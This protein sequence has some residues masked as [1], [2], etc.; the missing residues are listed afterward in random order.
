M[1]VKGS[2]KYPA[3]WSCST[4]GDAFAFL[5]TANNAREDLT[6]TDG[7][8]YLHY[9]DIHTKWRTVLDLNVADLP[10]IDENKVAGFSP[11]QDG[12]L[13]IA[14]ASEDYDG[15]GVAV[16]VRNIKEKKAVAGLHTLLLREKGSIF[17]NGFKGYLQYV[18][19]VRSQ[20][21]KIATGVSVYSISK[22]NLAN[23]S[24]PVPSSEE[25]RS[26]SAALSDVDALIKALDR[27]IA[28][29]RDIKQA[30]MQELLTG[31]RRLP[32]FEGEWVT[33][34]IKDLLSYEQPNQYIVQDTEYS[35]HGDIPVITANKSFVL[36]YTMEKFG[37]CGNIPAI[38]FDDFTIDCKYVNFPFK[39]KSS[40]IKLLRTKHERIDLRY[41]FERMQLIRFSLGDHKRYYI[42]EYQNVELSVPNYAEQT[43]IATVISDMDAEIAALETRCDKTKA[44]KQGMMQELLTGRIRLVEGGAA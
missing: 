23:I 13:I 5:P 34:R 9:G 26:I 19:D 4:I 18:P 35:E 42:S 40:A 44:L 31:K 10:K 24:I 30:A 36:G 25:Q 39:V 37:I 11:L 29:K 8:G 27:L 1:E 28:K 21:I 20:L 22:S 12:D 6:S 17:V 2:Q 41:V 16:E 7:V 15:V 38:V 3:D 33:V 14:D 32:G 43:A